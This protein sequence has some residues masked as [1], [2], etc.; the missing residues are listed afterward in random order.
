MIFLAK[1]GIATCTTLA[2]AG[3]WVFHEGVIKIDVDEH[4][5]NGEHVHLWVPATTVEV[6]LHLAPRHYLEHAA[7]QARPY[8]PALR[9]VAKELEKY[10]TA[11]LLDVHDHGEHVSL[12][13][14]SGRLYLDVVSSGENVHLS[15][16]A[17][18]VRDVADRLEEVAP[19]I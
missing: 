9:E 7:E 6:G 2:L 10:R 16:P 3:A 11:E 15:F 14:R 12:A 17:E 8:L 19:G 18:T 4:K 5:G 13:A 1:V